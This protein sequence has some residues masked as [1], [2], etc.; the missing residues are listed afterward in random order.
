M[1]PLY[2]KFLKKFQKTEQISASV[3]NWFT[4][5]SV[6]GW[7]NWGDAREFCMKFIL[8]EVME[9]KN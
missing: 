9:K 4:Y 5:G 8:T 3:T 6:F 2:F 1:V 7:W